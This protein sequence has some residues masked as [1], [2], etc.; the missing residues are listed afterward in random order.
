M[1]KHL[2]D[3]EVRQHYTFT[4]KGILSLRPK[5]LYTGQL[6]R[7]ITFKEEPH[8]HAFLEVIMVKNGNGEVNINKKVYSVKKGDIIVYH[9]Q[10]VHSEVSS[11]ENPFELFFFGATGFK[12]EGLESDCI[13]QDGVNPVIHTEENNK[14]FERLFSILATESESQQLFCDKTSEYLAR[15]ILL[16]ILRIVTYGNEEYLKTNEFYKSAKKYIDQNYSHIEN[17]DDVC[18]KLYIDKYYLS[19][20]FKECS[21]VSPLKYL[22]SKRMDYAKKL[23][24]QTDLPINEIATRCG[25]A[26]I[27]SFLKT[28]KNV[29]SVTPTTYREHYKKNEQ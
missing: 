20:L 13:L 8:N 1:T 10:V 15:T 19:H 23:L 12:I 28:F 25:Y 17:L 2:A 26:E 6:E 14:N 22:I 21:G 24:V 4:K 11:G 3:T 29:E 27:G 18:K 9:P 7:S 16:M 5:L